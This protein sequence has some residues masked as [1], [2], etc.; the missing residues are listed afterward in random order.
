MKRSKLTALEAFRSFDQ[1]FDG[2]ISKEDMAIS[3]QKFLKVRPEEILNSR[4]DRLFRI[5]SFYKTE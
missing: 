1:D 3:L 4:M 2:L 5:L